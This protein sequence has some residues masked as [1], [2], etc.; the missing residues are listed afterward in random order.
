MLTYIT[1][2]LNRCL[3]SISKF[4]PHASP[5]P[6]LCLAKSWLCFLCLCLASKS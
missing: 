2:A 5:S 4:L 1:I 3:A 6:R